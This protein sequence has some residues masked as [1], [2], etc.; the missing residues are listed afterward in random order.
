[1]NQEMWWE[2]VPE[3]LEPAFDG[4][5]TSWRSMRLVVSRGVEAHLA[6]IAAWSSDSSTAPRPRLVAK[7]CLTSR[8]PESWPWLAA[9]DGGS[10][11]FVWSAHARRGLE[12]M[13]AGEL[14]G[15]CAEMAAGD[16]FWETQVRSPGTSLLSTA[17]PAL[18]AK[19]YAHARRFESLRARA[20][21]A[22]DRPYDVAGM[23]SPG[24]DPSPLPTGWVVPE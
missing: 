23:F 16:L 4:A 13:L 24:T 11:A 7:S 12:A 2:V 8:E 14:R 6:V 19:T 3:C 22:L 9:N 1:M 15:R 17:F 5:R 20:L 18:W 10:V 21:F